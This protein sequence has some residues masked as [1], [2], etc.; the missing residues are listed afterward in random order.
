MGGQRLGPPPRTVVGVRKG[1]RPEKPCFIILNMPESFKD[2]ARTARAFPRGDACQQPPVDMRS[3]QG[4]PRTP[5]PRLKKLVETKFGSW[6]VG[7]MTGRGRELV[8]VCMR[9]N[10]DIMCV[11]ETKWKGKSSRELG[12][13]YKLFYSGE[14]CKRNG[15]GI[16]LSPK[17]KE[18]VIEVVRPSDRMMKMKLVIAGE[19]YNIISAY[20]PQVGETEEMKEDFMEKFEELILS[21]AQNEKLLVGAD[22]N[23]HVGRSADGFQQVHGG[24]GYG[25]RNKEGEKILE[26]AESVDMAIVNTFY[27]K[28]D[29]H[30]ITYKSGSHATQIDYVL[31]RR[32]DLKM[33]RNCKVIPGEAVVAQH[34]LVCAVLNIKREKGK[35]PDTRKRIKIWKLKGQKVKEYRDKVKEKYNSNTSTVEE[36]WCT[37]KTAVLEAA[38]EVCGCTKGGKHQGKE[39]WWWSEEVQEKIKKKKESFKAWQR[40]GSEDLREAYKEA[41]RETKK[42]VAKAKEEAWADWY[43]NM[44]TEEGEKMIYKVA[45]QRAQSRQDIGEVAV[46]KDKNGELLTD[47]EEIKGRWGEYFNQLLNVEND[48]EVLEECPPVEGPVQ[49]VTVEEVSKALKSMKSGKAAGASGVAV[50]LLKCLDKEGVEMLHSLLLKIWCAEE[51]PR[52]WEMS[53]IVTIYKQKGDPLECGNF[54]GIK[55]LEHGMK[56]MEKILERRLRTLIDIDNMQFGFSPGKGTTDAVFIIKQL[57][58]KHLEVNKDLFFTFVDLEKAYDRIPRDL[59]YWCLRK[60]MVPEELVRLVQVTYHGA[61][62]VVRTKYGKTDE[63]TIKVGLH[64]G[65]G[66]SPFLFTIILDVISEEFRGGLP[67]ELLFADDLALMADSETEL[68]NKWSKWQVGMEGKGLKVNTSKTEVM[69]STRGETETHIKDRKGE[70]LKQVNKFKYLGVTISDKGDSATAVRARVMAAWAKWRELA[71]VI[72]D[73]KM[74]RRLKTKLYSTI[75]RPVLLY[76]AESWTMGK[77]EERILEAT[78]MRMLRRIKGVTLKDKERSENIRKELGVDDINE[79]VREIRMRWY[80]HVMRMEVANPV[81]EVM[82]SVVAGKRPRGRPK[83]RWKDN[84]KQDMDHFQVCAEDAADRH[85]WRRKTKAADPAMRETWP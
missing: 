30:L 13:G 62:T 33:I 22:L 34:R 6:N 66:L 83:K 21:V 23:G 4:V 52:D 85:L 51:M 72:G 39:T 11:Q 17:Y 19:V 55:L 77:K 9:R 53:E 24:K 71:G 16:I 2:I 48:R 67:W 61:R 20:A 49:C 10:I 50:D 5:R 18:A 42:V 76:G 69:V 31:V 15:V 45:R 74:P 73:R 60:R 8:D 3:E 64:Q 57:Q 46:I 27:E 43:D 75:I 58:E 1:I 35:K 29:E 81:R 59:V 82:N 78:E 32:R 38:T 7:S 54:R 84:V 26:C 44:E 41:K 79:K 12:E 80:G 63:F 47:E 25:R 28:P 14:E 68:Q 36:H 56:V 40:G 37:L 70:E 65:S